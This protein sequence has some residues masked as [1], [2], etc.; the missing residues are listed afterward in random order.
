MKNY[1]EI[2]EWDSVFF[3]YKIA[4]I[5]SSKLGSHD[6]N[7][8]ITELGKNGF[9]LAYCFV[10][11][12]DETSIS[13]IRNASG[14]LVDEKITYFIEGF[15]E[16]EASGST[17][18]K[19]YNLTY[20]SENLKALALQSGLFSRFKVDPNFQNNE[21]E[22]LYVEW[23]KNSVIKKV[24]DEILVYFEGDD[25]K[26]FIT[27]AVK[28]DIGSIGLIAVDEKERGKSIGRKLI[29]ASFAFFKEKNVNKIEVVTQKANKAACLFYESLGFEVKN[30]INIY[31]LWIK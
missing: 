7:R 14:L 18:I 20:P 26:G 2:L 3:G 10:D 11:P 8:I 12:D 5:H 4:S 25:E 1:F 9:R 16:S 6:L 24:A 17:H 30:I 13:S 21:Y 28:K 15:G 27:L 23:I 19:L 29:N 22:N 31:H